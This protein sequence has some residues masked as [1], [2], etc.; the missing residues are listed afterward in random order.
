VHSE[1][2]VGFLVCMTATTP[3]RPAVKDSMME[4]ITGFPCRYRFRSTG[5]LG[6]DQATEDYGMDI[7]RR[8]RFYQP[9]GLLGSKIP[10]L[11]LRR[12]A[13]IFC[14]ESSTVIVILN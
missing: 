14:L 13:R 3:S 11:S 2:T 7:L 4:V 8:G 9:I 1:L 10:K 5:I 12:N 6:L